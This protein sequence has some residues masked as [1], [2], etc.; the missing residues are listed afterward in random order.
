VPDVVVVADSMRSPELRHEV[1]LPIPD[2]FFYLERGERRVV[3]LSS[4]EAVRVEAALEGLEVI[5]FEELGLDDLLAQGL[6]PWDAQRE[7][8][9][10]ACRTL[11]I[12]SAA[13][14]DTFP[15]LLA[16]H[17]RANGVEV[18][19]DPELFAARRRVKNAAE[20]EGIRRAQR[21]CEAAMDVARDLLR[22]A[23]AANGD[24]SVDGAPLTCERIRAALDE[25]FTAHGVV[26][27]ESIVSHG[28]QTAIGHEMGYGPIAPGEPVVLDLFPRDRESG[29]YAD[30]TRTFV[31]G[32][33]SDELREY[34]R[35]VLEALRRSTGEVRAGANGRALYEGVCELFHA[36]G[37]KTQLSKAPTE[38]LEDGFFHGL[39]HGIGLDVH[40]RP[41][42]GRGGAGDD[43]VA[44]DVITI[45]PGLYR[46]GYGGVRLEDLVLVTETGGEVLTDYPYDLEA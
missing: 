37:H 43:L 46:S 38:V 39:G 40:E 16:D 9:L 14:P 32:E 29:C 17:L 28:P 41:S 19:A 23:E 10:R 21:A 42:L 1:P 25:V 45:E 22:R 20:L 31:V 4:M 8:L 5:R 36:H 27:D 35:L 3:A 26:A 13:V 30:M 24:L 44:G 6:R 2:P 11:G 12:E 34:H 7:L 15:V 33:P 18:G